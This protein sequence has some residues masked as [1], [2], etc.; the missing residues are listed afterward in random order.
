MKSGSPS[1]RLKTGALNMK[2][3]TPTN[4][5]NTRLPCIYFDE[6]RM[7]AR[8]ECNM[9]ARGSFPLGRLAQLSDGG[10]KGL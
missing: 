3:L 8:N 10:Q 2:G 1:G 5:S 6:T 7:S 9:T 4:A